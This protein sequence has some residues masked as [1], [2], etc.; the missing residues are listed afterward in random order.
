MA[1]SSK[2]YE[3]HASDF[4]L[5]AS[6]SPRLSPPVW[7]LRGV[8]LL[9]ALFLAG[10]VGGVGGVPAVS[11]PILKASVILTTSRRPLV[12]QASN[13]SSNT[14]KNSIPAVACWLV[15]QPALFPLRTLTGNPVLG[16]KTQ[17]CGECRRGRPILLRS[18]LRDSRRSRCLPGRVGPGLHAMNYC[19]Y[20]RPPKCSRQCRAQHSC[21]IR[22][23][24]RF[25]SESKWTP[26]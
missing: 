4:S 6:R 10:T 16:G 3:T 12:G 22:E 5:G 14:F 26:T 20:R 9:F 18:P 24:A 1:I 8:Y 19:L 13:F 21:T 7:L 23:L 11:A 15:I 25:R 17:I 2:P